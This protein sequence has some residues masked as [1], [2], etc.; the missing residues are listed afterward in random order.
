[1]GC[2]NNKIA[3]KHQIQDWPSRGHWSLPKTSF[4]VHT[5]K[6]SD[7]PKFVQ[8]C[9][10]S[11][12]LH[13]AKN[14]GAHEEAKYENNFWKITLFAVLKSEGKLVWYNNSLNVNNLFGDREAGR[15]WATRVAVQLRRCPRQ[16]PDHHRANPPKDKIAGPDQLQVQRL[17]T[18]SP[19]R[20]IYHIKK[21]GNLIFVCLAEHSFKL[22]IAS[23]FLDEII[24]KFKEKYSS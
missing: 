19:R 7:L 20:Y 23:M 16:L 3:S 17:V 5:Y 8:I 22:K 4:P 2:Y 18:L 12:T 1:M 6:I 11:S 24:K 14:N 15:E 9:W 10:N 13:P 21:A